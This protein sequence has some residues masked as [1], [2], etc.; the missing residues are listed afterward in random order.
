[1]LQPNPLIQPNQTTP[2]RTYLQVTTTNYRTP[3]RESTSQLSPQKRPSP[4]QSEESTE[5]KRMYTPPTP[6]P[7]F[8][9][10]MNKP[11][12]LR[13]TGPTPD[14]R[15]KLRWG[16]QKS[17]DEFNTKTSNKFDQSGS[18]V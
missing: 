18:R 12:S 4:T 11:T 2:D 1:M 8:I 16:D 3:D 6:N 15:K 7:P 9:Q 14:V 5:I 13:T 17:N 10:P